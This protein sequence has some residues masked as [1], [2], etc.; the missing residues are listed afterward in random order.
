MRKV[1]IYK[2]RERHGPKKSAAMQ[3]AADRQEGPHWIV[4]DRAWREVMSDWRSEPAATIERQWEASG[5]KPGL[6][7][8]GGC[9]CD[10][11]N[12]ESE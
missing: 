6:A 11:P 1:L 12:L 10:P 3:A 5:Y 2:F 7:T 8:D 9:G 4:P